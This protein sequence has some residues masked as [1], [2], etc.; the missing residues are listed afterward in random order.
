M[1]L[2]MSILSTV[3]PV[4]TGAESICSNFLARLFHILPTSSNH[5]SMWAGMDLRTNYA[6]E[7]FA[8]E[9]GIPLT[10]GLVHPFNL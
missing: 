8:S 7:F 10:H 6:R 3:G 1:M 5:C 2:D 9:S 4:R